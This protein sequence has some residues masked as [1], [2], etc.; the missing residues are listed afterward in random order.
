MTKS[1]AWTSAAILPEPLCRLICE[2][3]E[4][5][6]PHYPPDD[7]S[8]HGPMAFLA[9]HGLGMDVDRI[10]RFAAEYRSRLVAQDRSAEIVTEADWEQHI[11]RR[12]SYSALRKFFA[13]Q[14]DSHGW[15]TTVA[16]YLPSLITGWVKDAF[17]PLIRLAYGIEFMVPPEIAAGLAYLAITGNDPQLATVAERPP[18]QDSGLRYLESLQGSRQASFLE[19]GFN[20]R[21]QAASRVATLRP[22]GGNQTDVLRALSRAGLEVFDA[23]HD[24]F[25]L[26]FVTG[27][28]AFRVCSLWA[29]LRWGAV[30]SVGIAA[31]YLAIGAPS[32]SALPTAS[33][34]L[35]LDAL[36]TDTDEHAIKIA[37]TSLMQAK[38]FRN[39]T[40][41]WVAN[42]YLIGRRQTST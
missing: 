11:G 13:S 23:T 31:A 25:A 21:Y 20:N 15:Q 36:C 2:H 12:E 26:H 42:R 1:P 32:F 39:P 38:A 10:E 9:M 3:G 40:Y 16:H 5:Y 33:A 22:A 34:E 29:G 7:N 8:D 4:R 19:G 28:H 6:A 17:H 41:R 37:Y 14:I 18:S 24:F 35:A 27:S 30:Y